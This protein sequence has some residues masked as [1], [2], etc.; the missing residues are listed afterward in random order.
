MI[1][2]CLY[3]YIFFFDVFLVAITITNINSCTREN[4][5]RESRE[6]Q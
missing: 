2:M 1:L 5:T 4:N 3:I 6:Y